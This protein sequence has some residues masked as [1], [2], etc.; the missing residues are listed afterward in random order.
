MLYPTVCLLQYVTVI[1]LVSFES[2]LQTVFECSF[3]DCFVLDQQHFPLRLCLDSAV[4]CTILYYPCC[5]TPLAHAFTSHNRIGISMRK[6]RRICHAESF[7]A[8][9]GLLVA[10]L[11]RNLKDESV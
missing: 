5:I 9:L 2:M 11:W 6:L 3:P 7:S 4:P 10:A 8:E 1:V